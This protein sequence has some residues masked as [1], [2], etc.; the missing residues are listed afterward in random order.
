MCS[1]EQLHPLSGRIR[2]SAVAERDRGVVA[3]LFADLH[4]RGRPGDPTRLCSAPWRASSRSPVRGGV[5]IGTVELRLAN[6]CCPNVMVCAYCGQ[7]ATMKIVSNPEHVCFEHALEFWTGLL[8]Y[9]T[10]HSGPCVRHE[11]LCTCRSC[12]ESSASSRRAIAIA[13]A[14]P[15]PRDHERLPMRLA[16]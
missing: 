15:S 14:G 4:A 1:S 12:E 16:S 6:L 2:A 7:P 5:Q 9:A 10:D 8:V 13:I 3:S 11:R